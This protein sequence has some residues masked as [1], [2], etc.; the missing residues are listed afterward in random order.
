MDSRPMPAIQMAA[1]KRG[2]P[3]L[4]FADLDVDGR[5][6]AVAGL[7]QQG[8]RAKQLATHYFEHLTVDPDEM[9]DLPAIVTGRAR[10][11]TLPDA[12]DS[13]THARGG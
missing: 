6:D 3:P 13:G 4:H 1:P 11:G 7:G 10:R 9:T 2:K 5:A 12:H 8:F